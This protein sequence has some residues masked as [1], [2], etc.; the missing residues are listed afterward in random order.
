[1]C[2]Q[3]EALKDRLIDAMN[4]RNIEAMRAQ[5]LSD[6]IDK[7]QSEQAS[8]L[9]EDYSLTEYVNYLKGQ[10]EKLTPRG[11]GAC[12]TDLAVT[13]YTLC[14]DCELKSAEHVFTMGQPSYLR[15]VLRESYGLPLAEDDELIATAR[16]HEGSVGILL[17]RLDEWRRWAGRVF[18]VDGER[19]DGDLREYVEA[20][21]RADVA[22]QWRSFVAPQED[23]HDPDCDIPS[24]ICTC[25]RERAA[26]AM[27][28][29]K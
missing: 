12:G 17:K 5:T 22:G 21:Y 6:M 19:G 24:A 28:E 18:M 25:A 10:I 13:T 7:M 16:R 4:S 26:R 20:A 3:C 15:K 27:R 29:Q 2:E 1:M 14:A 23:K 8:V 9:P 11:C